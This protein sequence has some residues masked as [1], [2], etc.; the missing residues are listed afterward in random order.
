MEIIHQRK[1]ILM[2]NF[3][4]Q[5]Q[6]KGITNI[7]ESIY[8][9]MGIPLNAGAEIIG[10]IS[11]S[12][13][14][15]GVTYTLEQQ[16]LLQSVADQAAG[17]IVKT[18]LLQ[19]SQRKTR[20]LAVLN[21]VSRQLTSTLDLEPLLRN[22]L[23]SATSILNCEAGSLLMIDE[24]T[25]ELVFRVTVGPVADNI[26]N[27][28]IPSGTGLVGKSFKTRSPVLVN[29]V[30]SSPDWFSKSDEETGFI[31]HALLVVPLIMQEKML[32]VIEVINKLDRLPFSKDDQELLT[33]FAAQAVVAIQNAK[34]YTMTDQALA[35]K[36]EEL[37]I[38][39]HIGRELNASLDTT[40]TLQISLEWALRQSGA[41]AGFAGLILEEG[42]RILAIQGYENELASYQEDLLPIEQIKIQAV[43]DDGSPHWFPIEEAG[44]KVFLKGGHGQLIVPIRRETKTIGVIVLENI[45][46]SKV[47][48]DVLNFLGRLSDQSSI[49][50]SNGQLYAEIKSANLAKSEFVSFV[51]HELKKPH[52]FHQRVLRIDCGRGCWTD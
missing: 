20:Q 44:R 34:L 21:E 50:V 36:V 46:A 15:P 39:Q 18:R 28:R 26:L 41:T 47:N 29:D 35:A 6:A 12:N 31:T 5:C 33:A 16:H 19:E 23:Q 40:R 17:A 30:Q 48:D 1:P 8:A 25:D 27:K 52:D 22:I 51:S 7:R 24:E 38:L 43:I 45:S 37:S 4:R 2:D 49:A 9:W 13:R 3:S 42:I 11:L 32:G 10:V 14:D